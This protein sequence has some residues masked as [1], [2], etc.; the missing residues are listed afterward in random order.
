MV[1]ELRKIN[2]SLYESDY[3]LWIL[4]TLQ[5]LHDQNFAELDLENLIEEIADLGREQRH[6][7]ESYL[8]QLLK[9]LLLYQFWESEKIC[10]GGWA[11]EI[12]NFR[13]ELEILLRSQTLANYCFSILE[14]TY[15]KARGSAQKKTGLNNFPV[16]CPYSL[17]A[18]LSPDWLPTEDWFPVND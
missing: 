2:K 15:Q 6:K 5:K 9:H 18:A 13:A 10:R 8:R 4:E 1:A 7:V 17:E 11:D 14:L 16:N 12:D 3:A